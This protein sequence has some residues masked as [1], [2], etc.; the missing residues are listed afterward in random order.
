MFKP[1]TLLF[2]ALALA[3]PPAL[4]QSAPPAQSGA[5]T[6]TPAPALKARLDELVTLLNGK[7]D[8][9]ALFSP[10]FRQAVPQAKFQA[11]VDQLT[12]Q[13]GRATG[14]ASIAPATAW[15]ATVQIAYEKLVATMQVAVDPA[16]PHQVTGLRITGAAPHADSLAKLEADFR[17]L[18][19]GSGFGIY[20][21]DDAG[22]TPVAEFNGKTAAPLGSAF[23]LWILAEAAREIAAGERHW[24]DVVRVGPHSLPSGVLQ[25]WPEHAPVTLQTL[26]SLM[27]SIS[28]NT[29][30]DTLLTTLG[31]DKVGEMVRTVGVADP[32]RTLPVLTTMQAFELKSPAHAALAAAWAKATPEQRAKLLADNAAAFAATPIDPHMFDGKPLAINSVEWF[33]SPEDIARTLNWLR[34]HG[35][36]TTRAILAITPGVDPA[37]AVHFA[38]IGYKGG[39]EPGVLTLNFLVQT[40][41]GEWFAVTGN[42]HNPDAAVGDLT[43]ASLMDRALLLAAR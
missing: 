11:Y 37:T 34:L 41:A 2:A 22:V 25:K 43:F 9:A 7:G 20:K 10:A 13:G 3:A 6:I 33:A 19:G 27:I 23:K 32:A 4:A 38:Y 29:A 1:T 26:A 36:D 40:K 42:W 31:Q 28:D 30:T 18:P 21:L 16:A 8:Y 17:A 39:S 15:N 14:I 24:D 12:A 5:S 35:D